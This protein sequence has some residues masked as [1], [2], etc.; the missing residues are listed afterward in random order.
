MDR[1][2]EKE[3]GVKANAEKPAGKAAYRKTKRM[4]ASERKEQILQVSQAVIINEGFAQFSLRYV[5]DQA[6][7]RLATLQ[8]YFATKE[9]LFRATF[10]YAIAQE[11]VRFEAVIEEDTLKTPGS[12]L[13]SRLL[14]HL[15]AEQNPETVGIFYQL[16]AQAYLDD[17]AHQLMDDF[18]DRHFNALAELIKGF[19]RGVSDLEAKR[20]AMMIIAF[21]EGMS[22]FM[23]ADRKDRPEMADIETHVLNM[24]FTMVN[25]PNQKWP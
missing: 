5:A 14:G 11:R 13:K 6:G 19:N 1:T 12:K 16:W 9:E 8:H 18:Y 3:E 2:V 20:R 24:I 15:R 7:I 25:T 4:K 17:F 22:L 10:E 21:L 23:G